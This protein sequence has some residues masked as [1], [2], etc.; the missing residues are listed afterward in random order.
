MSALLTTLSSQYP[1]LHTLLVVLGTLVVL[2]QALAPALP[3]DS[4]LMA[5]I[6]A[7]PL[8]AQLV[9]ALLSFAVIKF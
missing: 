1:A 9:T 4:K 2:A 5:K 7:V 8:L 3:A 6:N